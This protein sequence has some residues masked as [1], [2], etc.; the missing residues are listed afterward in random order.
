MPFGLFAALETF[1]KEETL[2]F[3]DKTKYQDTITAQIKMPKYV[4][5]Y[6]D[7]KGMGEHVRLTLHHLGIEFE[8]HRIHRTEEWPKFKTENGE[9][10]FPMLSLKYGKWNGGMKR[11]DGMEWNDNLKSSEIFKIVFFLTPTTFRISKTESF[12]KQNP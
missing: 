3:C 2:V 9:T 6:F 10:F 5:H 11:N 4:L 8:D 7:F 12:P 1:S